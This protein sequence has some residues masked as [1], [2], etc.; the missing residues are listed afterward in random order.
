MTT[1][2]AARGFSQSEPFGQGDAALFHV[3]VLLPRAGHN[4]DLLVARLGNRVRL[5]LVE[6]EG[7][8]PGLGPV[9]VAVLHA[10]RVGIECSPLI[11][12]PHLGLPELVFVVDEA[13][14]AQYLALRSRGFQYVVA[15]QDLL[16]WLPTALPRLVRLARARRTLMHACAEG[17]RVSDAPVPPARRRLSERLHAAETSFRSMYMR[18]ILAEHGSRRRAAEEA[19]V[20][21][22]SFC[23]ML[24]KLG[25]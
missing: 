24:R 20:P 7:P 13:W 25:I 4:F 16:N 15:Q 12:D 17:A 23:E 19:G 5:T 9:D 6:N 1:S 10:N 2:V 18:A 3:L 14:S 21:Y 22:R 8:I 11:N